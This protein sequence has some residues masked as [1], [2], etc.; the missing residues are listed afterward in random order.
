MIFENEIKVPIVQHVPIEPAVSLA[1]LENDGTLVVHSANQGP[2]IL[3]KTISKALGLNLDSVRVIKT[4][5]GRG[6]FGVKQDAVLEPLNGALAL[7]EK[8]LFS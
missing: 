7:A 2:H 6:G 5:V 1:Y 8:G 3:R 4:L